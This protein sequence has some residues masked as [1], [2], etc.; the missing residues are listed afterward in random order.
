MSRLN[1]FDAKQFKTSTKE[2]FDNIEFM[3][4]NNYMLVSLD[5]ETGPRYF[6]ACEELGKKAS[7]VVQAFIEVKTP[8]Y[9]Q[10]VLTKEQLNE[11]EERKARFELLN[12]EDN[13]NGLNRFDQKQL[14]KA[15]EDFIQNLEVMFGQNFLLV[16]LEGN[17]KERFYNS[18]DRLGKN[19]YTVIQQ[20][21]ASKVI[22]YEE[23]AKEKIAEKEREERRLSLESFQRSITETKNFVK[24]NEL[25]HSN[26]QKIS[27]GPAINNNKDKL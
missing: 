24:T 19:P 10:R 22:Q 1:K 18:C 8:K 21:I 2:L 5:Q 6:A 12:P 15:S 14:Q 16:R 25:S 9:E 11:I 27:K 13:S 23:R 4:G 3:I 17:L 7:D 26:L 20:L